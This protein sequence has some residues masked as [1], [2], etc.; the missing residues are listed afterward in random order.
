MDL[1]RI[2]MLREKANALPKQPGVYYMK[3]REG[4]I[5]Y[6]GKAKIL[7]NRVSS[8]FKAIDNHLPKVYKMVSNVY[9]FDY[10]ITSSEMEALI[11]ECAEIKRYKPKYNI[12][13]KDDKAYPYIKITNGDYPRIET[14][15]KRED[16]GGKYFGPF[17]GNIS[18]AVDTARKVFGI[19]SCSRKF[20]AEI[21]KMRHCIEYDIGNC[22]GVCT[23]NVTQ[24]EYKERIAS[25][26]KFFKGAESEIVAFLQNEMEIAANKLEYEKAAQI[27][28][29]IMSVKKL[30]ESQMVVGSPSEERDVIGVKVGIAKAVVSFIAIRGGKITAKRIEFDENYRAEIKIN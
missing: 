6:V 16:D 8:Y 18:L 11:L 19:P 22:I 27:R 10:I 5:I 1:D 15:R 17:T 2:K 14:T 21:G 23:G 28:D 30:S 24:D 25:A 26:E 20:P 9:D 29:K 3:N 4:K 12:L 13:L 7:P